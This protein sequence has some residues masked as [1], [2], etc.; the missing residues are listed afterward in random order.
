MTLRNSYLFEHWGNFQ[1]VSSTSSGLEVLFQIDCYFPEMILFI[2]NHS[3]KKHLT[4]I[5][6]FKIISD[7]YRF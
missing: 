6:L 7:V 4:V 1:F 2:E 3:K 5:F